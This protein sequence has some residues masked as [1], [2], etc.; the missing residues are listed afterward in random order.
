MLSTYD[1]VKDKVIR[2]VKSMLGK[3]SA[4]EMD[5]SNSSYH[6]YVN[7]SSNRAS[8]PNARSLKEGISEEWRA[9]RSSR[10]HDIH[11]MSRHISADCYPHSS[12]GPI[13]RENVASY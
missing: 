5:V 11:V 3:S 2:D 4:E 13:L 8:S 6:R 12:C 1:V 7:G 9:V 10:C